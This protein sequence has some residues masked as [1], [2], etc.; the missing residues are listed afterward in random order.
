MDINK[1]YIIIII[2][3]LSFE[4]MISLKNT[5][6]G[7]LATAQ[8]LPQ[9]GSAGAA[10][11]ITLGLLTPRLQDTPIL[12]AITVGRSPERRFGRISTHSILPVD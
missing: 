12:Y 5:P 6:I 1:K 2:I 10:K 9:K 4:I 3:Y 11:I 7:D 8:H